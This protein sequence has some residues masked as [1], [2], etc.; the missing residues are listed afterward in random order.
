MREGIRYLCCTPA[1]PVIRIEKLA[2]MLQ[3]VKSEAEPLVFD[4]ADNRGETQYRSGTMK[5]VDFT[6]WRISRSIS[7]WHLSWPSWVSTSW[8][9]TRAN[10]LPSGHPFHPD[11]KLAAAWLTGQI[12]RI[13]FSKRYHEP[14]QKQLDTSRQQGF[15]EIETLVLCVDVN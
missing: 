9:T 7:S 8:W 10:F 1:K 5:M 12:W 4:V 3:T 13:S 6:F 2:V 11:G 14:A 15:Y